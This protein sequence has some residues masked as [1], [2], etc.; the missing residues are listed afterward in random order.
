MLCPQAA[1]LVRE[2]CSKHGIYYEECSLEFGF[3]RVLTR[4]REVAKLVN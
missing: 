1:K 4:L 3:V 2:L